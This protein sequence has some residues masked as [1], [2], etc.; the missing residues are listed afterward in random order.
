MIAA[1]E[2]PGCAHPWLHVVGGKILLSGG[3]MRN[4]NTTDTFLWSSDDFGDSWQPLLQGWQPHSLSGDHNMLVQGMQHSLLF[5]PRHAPVP[6][7]LA[8]AS[9]D[10]GQ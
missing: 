7:P 4:R 9:V 3:R 8:I 2:P 10:P 5:P 6:C 1:H